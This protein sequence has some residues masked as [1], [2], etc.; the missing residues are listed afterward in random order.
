MTSKKSFFTLTCVL[1]A[2]LCSPIKAET[3][4]KER[5][6]R[7]FNYGIFCG[8]APTLFVLNDDRSSR[9]KA[10]IGLAIGALFNLSCDL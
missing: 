5:L 2:S 3:T 8:V 7:A 10:V 6:A 9:K 4:N 1:F